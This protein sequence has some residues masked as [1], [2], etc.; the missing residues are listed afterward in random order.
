[1]LGCDTMR[2]DLKG[3]EVD[4]ANWKEFLRRL[5]ESGQTLEEYFTVAVNDEVENALFHDPRLLEPESP[6]RPCVP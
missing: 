2:I 4:E 6:K 5:A 1:M 3:I